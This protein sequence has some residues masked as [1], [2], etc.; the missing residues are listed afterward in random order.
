M[1]E[2]VKPD[3]MTLGS[4]FAKSGY[5]QDARDAAQAVVKMLAGSELG[6]GP[7][8]SMTG[9]YIVKGRVTLS[10]NLMASAVKRSGRYNYRVKTLTDDACEIVFYD[11]KDELHPPS[12]FTMEDA[13]R[14][15]LVNDN[16]RKFSRNML[17]AR[18]MSNGV[19]FHCPDVTGGPAYTPDELGALV[20]METGEMTER[21][22]DER[23][24]PLGSGPDT[25][26]GETAPPEEDEPG[27]DP[28]R[29][30]KIAVLESIAKGYGMLKM[31][32]QMQRV[33]YKKHTGGAPF[34]TDADAD[35]DQVTLDAL[36]ALRD[37]LRAL[38]RAAESR[39]R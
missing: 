38:H 7:V 14:A 28:E 18:A 33:L 27:D 12:V 35:P 8:A 2:L 17:F 9:I 19:K 39:K 21:P 31:S 3:V 34:Y 26:A 13:K 20:D 4:V 1:N 29:E 22:K 16:Y 32:E 5:F 11:G 25:A 30:E 36:V 37:E 24:V 15:G 23:I 10:A 6:F